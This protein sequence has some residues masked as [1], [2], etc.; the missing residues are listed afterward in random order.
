MVSAVFSWLNSAGCFPGL[1]SA[2]RQKTTA[3]LRKHPELRLFARLCC[4]LCDMLLAVSFRGASLTSVSSTNKGHSFNTAFSLRDR[5]S[6][7][8]PQRNSAW[9]RERSLCNYS[10]SD[11]IQSEP[12]FYG[13]IILGQ[14][15]GSRPPWEMCI[16]RSADKGRRGGPCCVKCAAAMVLRCMCK[17][18]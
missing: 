5:F 12:A 16:S 10:R 13:A 2:R 9:A 11:W 8:G 15:P 18:G 1:N 17:V 14:K 4:C 6:Q 7:S 3:H